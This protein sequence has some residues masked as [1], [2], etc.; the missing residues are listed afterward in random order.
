MRSNQ[1]QV[2]EISEHA[3]QFD[4]LYVYSHKIESSVFDTNVRVLA[5]PVRKEQINMASVLSYLYVMLIR[6][7]RGWIQLSKLKPEH[8]HLIISDPKAESV[9]LSKHTL[10]NEVDDLYLGYLMQSVDDTFLFLDDL[11]PPKFRSPDR[12]EI[13]SR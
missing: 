8:R 6:T 13:K 1:Y 2:S 12:F 10:E 4:Q 3:K 11:A 5:R 7:F 9:Y